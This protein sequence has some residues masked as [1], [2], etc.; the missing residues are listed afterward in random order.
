MKLKLKTLEQIADERENEKL[1]LQI[2]RLARF[3]TFIQP[4]D[5][6]FH[7]F[8]AFIQLLIK[9][10]P[11]YVVFFFFFLTLI[12]TVMLN[13]EI[14][15]SIS[16]FYSTIE[17]NC[18]KLRECLV[19]VFKQPFLIFKQYCTHF[20]TLFHPHVFSQIFLNNNFQFL[21]TYTKRTVGA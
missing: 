1:L 14:S 12:S 17:C 5:K 19:C 7:F 13:V 6:K 2:W 21:N 11:I 4:V 9:F 20:N 8:S 3:S 18:R 16:F 10:F 15:T